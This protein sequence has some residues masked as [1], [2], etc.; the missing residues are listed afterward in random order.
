MGS[1]AIPTWGIVR[2]AGADDAESLA[3]F[4][5]TSFVDTFGSANT[6][7]NM[8]EY[9]SKAFGTDVQR[10]ELLNPRNAIFIA[11]RD[12]VLIGYVMMR[13]TAVPECV[14]DRNALEIV[15]LYVSKSLIGGGLG[16][17][18]MQ[19]AIDEARAQGK[20]TIWLCV[21]E[22]NPA[23]IAFYTRWGYVRRGDHTFVLGSD[24]QTDHIMTREVV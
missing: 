4:A 10:E 11:E 23:A 5:R 3:S 18:L 15:R 12:G 7:S 14:A 6:E 2:R 17:A 21:W 19:R 20:S 1:S 8:S 22:E 9:L 16:S 13:D 24:L